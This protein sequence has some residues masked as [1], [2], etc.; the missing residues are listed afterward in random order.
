MRNWERVLYSLIGDDD[1]FRSAVRHALE[2]LEISI[3][4]FS[5]RTRMPK[6]TLYKIMS[7]KKKDIRLSNFKEIVGALKE[8]EQGK[9]V[10]G[11]NIALIIDRGTLENVKKEIVVDGQS[12]AVE[13]YPATDIEEA[14]I[15]GIH[16]ERDGVR[17]I[18]C[19]PI[20]AHTLEKVVRIPV[21]A[22]RPRP[23]Q[24]QG[25]VETAAKKIL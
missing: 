14:I 21:I 3:K 7:S 19:G 6:S 17:A 23:D 15:Q 13:G 18:I 24:I 9:S 12:Y 22:F 2:E 10:K 20:T 16:A 25:A 5:K 4:D 11:K 1:S 8:V